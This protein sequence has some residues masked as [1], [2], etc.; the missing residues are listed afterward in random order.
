[1]TQTSR[2][3]AFW[4]FAT[5]KDLLEISDLREKLVIDLNAFQIATT[6]DRPLIDF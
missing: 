5:N 1:M 3:I 2:R 6:T 4:V